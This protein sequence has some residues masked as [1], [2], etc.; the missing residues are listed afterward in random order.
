MQL[1]TSIRRHA[2][3]PGSARGFS[4]VEVMVA[5]AV[6][7]V[8]LLGIAKMQT[9]A[10]SS[11][12]GA[13]KRALAALQAASL[14]ASMHADRPYWA[15][16]GLPPSP[17]T[18]TGSTVN[19]GVLGAPADCTSAGT[20]PCDSV[21]V[22]AYDLQ[23]WA[24]SVATLLGANSTATITCSNVANVP[25]TCTIQ[26]SWTEKAIA[27]NAT[28]AAN[29]GTTPGANTAAFNNPTYTLVVEP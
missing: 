17:L 8:G 6:L 2:A 5:L 27:I 12:T 20:A 14:A 21:T 22:A 16:G 3:R 19:D 29:T 13:S 28:Q 10:L 25:V 4:L 24:A 26:I 23:N 15:A 9:L 11:T 7:S 1:I 18:V